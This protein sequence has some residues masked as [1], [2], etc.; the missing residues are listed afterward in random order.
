MPPAAFDSNLDALDIVARRDANRRL[1]SIVERK[2]DP[3]GLVYDR[4]RYL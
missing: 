1:R 3:S 2:A 4:N